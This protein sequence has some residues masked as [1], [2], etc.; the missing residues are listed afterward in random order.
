ML[1]TLQK[2]FDVELQE[3]SDGVIKKCDKITV[4]NLSVNSDTVII[5]TSVS[6]W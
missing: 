3:E 1:I 5:D 6:I 2:D 4:H